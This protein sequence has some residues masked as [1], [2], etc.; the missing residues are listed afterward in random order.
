MAGM[1]ATMSMKFLAIKYPK[2][3]IHSIWFQQHINGQEKRENVHQYLH[4]ITQIHKP[5]TPKKP[6]SALKTQ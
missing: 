3:L 5:L 4:T 6:N 1:E 2:N